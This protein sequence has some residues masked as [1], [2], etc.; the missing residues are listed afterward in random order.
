MRCYFDS[1]VLVSLYLKDSN[2]ERAINAVGRTIGA[3]LYTQLH[4]IEITNA[5]QLAHFQN[6]ISSDQAISA[7]SVIDADIESGAL[8]RV[9]LHWSMTIRAALDLS[10]RFSAKYGCRTLD[11]MHLAAATTL[12]V[13]NFITFDKRQAAVARELGF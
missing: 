7:L 10:R 11:V 13:D 1:S 6:R 3:P 2:S 4:A 8:E 9:H 12:K 5:A